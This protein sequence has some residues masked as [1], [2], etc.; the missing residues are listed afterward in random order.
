MILNFSAIIAY[1][2]DDV[3]TFGTDETG[4]SLKKKGAGNHTPNRFYNRFRVLT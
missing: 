4:T 1:F 2:W 3:N